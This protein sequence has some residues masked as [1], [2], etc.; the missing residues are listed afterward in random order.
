MPDSVHAVRDFKYRLNQWT[1]WVE[2]PPSK[3]VLFA[4][5]DGS[6]VVGFAVAKPNTDKAIDVPGEMHACYIL[7]EYRG[8]EIGPLALTAIAN[9]LKENDLWPVCL[10]AFRSNPYRRIYPALGCKAEV[11][12]DRHIG[13][14][15]LP[16]IGYR[17]TD[18]ELLINRLDRMRDSSSL[19]QTGSLRKRRPLLRL[20]G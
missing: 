12:R 16:E 1:G 5:V 19:R 15:A 11:F 13:G 14:A 18:Y 17:V 8:G 3:S 4:L 9:F 2:N 10:W 20:H 6:R 7:P